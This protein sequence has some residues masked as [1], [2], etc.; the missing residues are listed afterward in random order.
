MKYLVGHKRLLKCTISAAALCLGIVGAYDEAHAQD[1]SQAIQFNI[2]SQPLAKSLREYARLAGQQIVFTN[3]LM[4]QQEVKGLQGSYS[5]DEALSQLL[6]GTGLVADR[7]VPGTIMIRR[8]RHSD[9]SQMGQRLAYAGGSQ[10]TQ[11]NGAAAAD[12]NPQQAEPQ[13]LAVESV[14]VT[15]TNIAGI[16]LV[17]SNLMTVN[18]ADIAETGAQTVGQML[19]NVPAITGFGSIGQGQVNTAS[20]YPKILLARFGCGSGSCRV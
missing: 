14:T 2:P 19:L 15:G 16:N 4:P 12:P 11:A 9:A 18:A 3:D 20:Y 6:A 1:H 8:E 7:S 13:A 5:A 17:G 10:V